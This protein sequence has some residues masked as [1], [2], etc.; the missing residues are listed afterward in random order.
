M[1]TKP[2]LIERL[3]AVKADG[4][5]WNWKDE[6][7]PKDLLREYTATINEAI[8]ALRQ[9]EW[10]K[11]EDIPEEW[12][13]GRCINL[14]IRLEGDGL[15]SMPHCASNDGVWYDWQGLEILNTATHA[16]LPPQPPE[17]SS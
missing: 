16:M 15:H 11:I 7:A 4:F 13:D 10:V 6:D 1:N 3:K 5:D 9:R 17:Q 12:K 14:V 2:T 8:S